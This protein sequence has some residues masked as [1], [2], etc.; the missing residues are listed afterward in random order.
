MKHHELVHDEIRVLDCDLPASEKLVNR[1]AGH[2][3]FGNPS[4]RLLHRDGV[5]SV[6]LDRDTELSRFD[7]ERS[8]L[9]DEDR[10]RTRINQVQ[11]RRENSMI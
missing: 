11:A 7:A 1:L 8:V 3:D 2:I 4:I 5:P 6:V 9:R 10:A